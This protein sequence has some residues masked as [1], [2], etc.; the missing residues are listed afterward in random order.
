MVLSQKERLIETLKGNKTAR[1]PVICPGG[2]M[3][4]ALVEIMNK[5][6]H[7]LPSSHR[8]EELM[9][10]LAVDVYEETG[11]E[12]IAL[13]FCMTVEAEIMGSLIDMGSLSCEPKIKKEV[14]PSVHNV[15]FNE[16]GDLLG[17]GRVGTVLGAIRR[18][19][20]MYPSVPVTGV[21]SGPLSV[22]ASVVDPMTF[23]K[24]LHKKRQEAHQVVD[25]LSRLI[26]SF[27]LMMLEAG[28]SVITIADPSAS[29]EI[30]GPVLFKEYAVTYLNRVVDA[31]HKSQASVIVHICGD[32]NSVRHLIRSI[33]ADAVSVDAMV[34][35]ARLKHDF[36]EITT[37]GNI[38]TQLLRSGPTDRIVKTAE[39]L[40][41]DNVDIVA[42]ACGLDIHT[43]LKSIRAFTDRVKG[44]VS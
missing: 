34:N 37:M 2:M 13:P 21:V 29:G 42:P 15:P 17:S 20:E 25:H 4:A 23:F 38:S 22:A 41:A 16:I 19:S 28:A 18:V 8:D 36:P 39:K 40:I 1:P 31:V 24:E 5:T 3:N 6:G 35:L 11:F 33:R 43:P 9:A 7:T 27:A 14:Y 12:N 10:Q 26:A 30:L 44:C 32:M